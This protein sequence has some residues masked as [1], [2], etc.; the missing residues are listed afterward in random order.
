MYQ[1][2]CTLLNIFTIVI[3]YINLCHVYGIK[4]TKTCFM[5]NN[6]HCSAN[7]NIPIYNTIVCVTIYNSQIDRLIN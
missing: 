2:G 5:D 4:W 1:M 6:S 7:R 3:I